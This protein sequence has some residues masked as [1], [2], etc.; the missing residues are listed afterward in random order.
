MVDVEK[1]LW[2]KTSNYFIVRMRVASVWS[3]QV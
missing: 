3:S 2:N 1:Y